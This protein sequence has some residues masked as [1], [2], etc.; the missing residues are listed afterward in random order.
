MTD[1]DKII[2]IANNILEEYG[3]QCGTDLNFPPLREKF[4]DKVRREAFDIHGGV[5][6]ELEQCN[7]HTANKILKQCFKSKN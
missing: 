3:S 1:A 6:H 4:V 7:Y 5:Y 2:E